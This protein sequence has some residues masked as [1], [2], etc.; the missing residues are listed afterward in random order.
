M[1][2]LGCAKNLVDSEVMLGH[3]A[4]SGWEFVQDPREADVLVVNTC[5]FIGPAREESIQ[6]ILEAAK[7]KKT[8]RLRRLIVA[9][10]LVQRYASELRAELP[11]VDSFIGLDQL[12][13][14]V[15][16]A[17][18]GIGE[19]PAGGLPVWSRSSYLYDDTS[20][21]RRSTPAWTN[22]RAEGSSR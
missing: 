3:L 5:S 1:I 19:N 10:C 18:P 21:R 9:G 2:S 8:G 20:P 4:D 14:I 17:E 15:E 11:E 16:V 6:A 13:R 22:S 7:Y 12:H